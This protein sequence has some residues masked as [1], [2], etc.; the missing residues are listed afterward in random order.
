MKQS[1]RRHQSGA[2]YV[3]T[4]VVL[5]VVFFMFFCTWQL[6][7]LLTASL[8]VRHAAISAARAAAVIGPDSPTFYG[9]QA[10]DD[11]ASGLRFD[12][13]QDAAWMA[14]KAHPHFSK[15]TSHVVVDGQFAG[16]NLVTAHVSADYSCHMPWVNVVCGGGTRTLTAEA[17][18]PYQAA[19]VEWEN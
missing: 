19:S 4:L 2:V 15:G 7:D 13:V 18:F 14:L 8:V 5:P 9:G 17:S 6:V 3:E 11:V 1:K 12:A 10:R 16:N